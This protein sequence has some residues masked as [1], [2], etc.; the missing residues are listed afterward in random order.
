MKHKTTEL[1]GAM[2]D[3]AVI[4][5]LGMTDDDAAGVGLGCPD[6]RQ[7]FKP[8]SSW[9]HGGPIIER[10]RISV[11]RD[12]LDAE[13]RWVAGSQFWIEG[14]FDGVMEFGPTPLIAAMRA[15]VASKL[16]DQVEL[17]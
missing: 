16:G 13:D 6:W 12:A 1:A 15:F 11:L 17:P 2:L 9:A 7:R 3:A 14:G 5:A 4:A 10:E 8:S